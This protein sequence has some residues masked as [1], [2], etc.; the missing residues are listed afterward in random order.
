MQDRIRIVLY[1]Y[2]RIGIVKKITEQRCEI[3]KW[4]FLILDFS[5]N[6]AWGR[7]EID[8]D[9]VFPGTYR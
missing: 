4:K 5:R 9:S 7:R 3:G 6:F 8:S 1:L 2:R